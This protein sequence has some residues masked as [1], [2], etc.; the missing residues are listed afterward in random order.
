MEIRF[1]L[2][3]MF[4]RLGKHECSL[5]WELPVFDLVLENILCFPLST[6]FCSAFKAVFDI[7]ICLLN[8]LDML[9]DNLIWNVSVYIVYRYRMLRS[10]PYFS[11]YIWGSKC[12]NTDCCIYLK[13]LQITK[14][15]ENIYI[16]VRG[17]K[18]RRT[19]Y[20]IRSFW[21][22]VH[23]DSPS[24]TLPNLKGNFEKK[25]CSQPK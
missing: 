24:K 11:L 2:K 22:T 8:R 6:S 21:P 4:E 23:H 15:Y 10:F 5:E 25:Y 7:V 17:Q 13:S 1:R 18:P 19:K 9:L 20:Y 12:L 14:Q 3:M 16:M